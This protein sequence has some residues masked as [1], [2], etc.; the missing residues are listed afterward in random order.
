MSAGHLVSVACSQPGCSARPAASRFRR[1]FWVPI[2]TRPPIRATQP[3]SLWRIR[4]KTLLQETNIELFSDQE[5]LT[6]SNNNFPL[7]LRAKTKTT[8]PTPS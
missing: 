2:L 4:A 1:A 5:P 7:E 6:K 3:W 8:K